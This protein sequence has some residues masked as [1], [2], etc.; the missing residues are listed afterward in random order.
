MPITEN[1]IT[2]TT[3]I[4]KQECGNSKDSVK[5]ICTLG[6]NKNVCEGQ[7][8]LPK[9][10]WLAEETDFKEIWAKQKKRINFSQVSR[11]IGHRFGLFKPYSCF[12]YIIHVITVALRKFCLNFSWI[13]IRVRQWLHKYHESNE[14]ARNDE[15]GG[16]AWSLGTVVFRYLWKHAEKSLKHFE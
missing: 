14:K 16:Y 11:Q 10:E 3:H 1:F 8:C 2:Q 12:V 4:N 13:R 5:P 9:Y 7:R 15:T 6:K